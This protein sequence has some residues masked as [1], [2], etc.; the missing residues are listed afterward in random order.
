MPAEQFEE[1]QG[2]MHELYGQW[3]EEV[4]RE[5]PGGGIC[6]MPLLSAALAY[7]KHYLV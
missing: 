7:K 5:K 4:G 1:V 3:V 2:D 6:S